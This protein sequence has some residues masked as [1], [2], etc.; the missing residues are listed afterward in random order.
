MFN[1]ANSSSSSS[2]ETYVSENMYHSTK[3][4]ICLNEINFNQNENDIDEDLDKES[5]FL[6]RLI[7]SSTDITRNDLYSSPINREN[8]QRNNRANRIESALMTSDYSPPFID[9][10]MNRTIDLI[11]R[12]GCG[13]ENP[14]SQF[15]DKHVQIPIVTD[16]NHYLTLEHVPIYDRRTIQLTSK[17]LILI[18]ISVFLFVILLPKKNYCVIRMFCIILNA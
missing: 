3:S 11:K 15:N 16:S 2:I 13:D 14:L 12:N 17:Q 1:K 5:K 7:Q 9:L 6:H 18:S 8:S 4:I 10:N